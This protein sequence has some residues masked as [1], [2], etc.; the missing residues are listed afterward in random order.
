MIKKIINNRHQIIE[1]VAMVTTLYVVIAIHSFRKAY[2][3]R[4]TRV[5]WNN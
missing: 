5:N 1:G 3:A 2:D 4:N